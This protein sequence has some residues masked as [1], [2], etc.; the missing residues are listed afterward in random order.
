MAWWGGLSCASLIF[1]RP[2]IFR[3]SMSVSSTGHYSHTALPRRLPFT[4]YLGLTL[5]RELSQRHT[6]QDELHHQ[7]SLIPANEIYHGCWVWILE[8]RSKGL[9]STHSEV[10]GQPQDQDPNWWE[11]G[12][13]GHWP[14]LCFPSA[15]LFML[16]WSCPSPPHPLASFSSLSASTW[17]LRYTGSELEKSQVNPP[18]SHVH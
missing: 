2:P 15:L 12:L 10:K 8:W 1:I 5:V 13:T 16:K 14:T 3:R 6:G 7:S 18:L 11:G 4:E 9:G 17:L